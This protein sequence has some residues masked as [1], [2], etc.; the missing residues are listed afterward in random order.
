MGSLPGPGCYSL[1]GDKPTLTD[2]FVASG[3]INPE[4]FLGGTK[5]IHLETARSII[6]ESIAQPLNSSLEVACRAIIGRAFESVANLIAQAGSELRQDFADHTLF[7]FGGNGGLF[8]CGVAEKAGLKNVYFFSLGPVFSAFGSSVSDIS[9]VYERALQIS[10]VSDNS[11]GELNHIVQE[12][13]AEALRDLLGEGIKPGPVEYAMELEIARAGRPAIAL[14]CPETSFQD[15]R[16]LRA[17]CDSNIPVGAESFVI[18]LLRVQIRKAMPKPALIEIPLHGADS[19]HAIKGT[20]KVAWGSSK[21]EAQ[22]YRWESLLPG[23][24]VKGCAVLEGANS[25]Y[26]VP[27]GWTLVMDKFGNAKLNR[28]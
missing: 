11:V 28:R 21:G 10:S 13:K 25:T 20:R 6:Q 9:H 15:A 16:S 1:G 26:F 19:S 8:A 27:E 18:E 14:A 17:F 7:A 12:I 23:N 3:L 5:P 2:A 4:Y 24:C 22:L